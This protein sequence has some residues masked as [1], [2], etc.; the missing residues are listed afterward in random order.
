M[1][2]DIFRF[3]EVDTRF[4]PD[5]STRYLEASVPIAPGPEDR[6][7]LSEFYREDVEK[8]AALLNRDLSGWV[9]P[10]RDRKEA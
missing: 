6:A 5:M 8:L 4:R 2:V 1:L 10:N 9:L 7:F 3:L